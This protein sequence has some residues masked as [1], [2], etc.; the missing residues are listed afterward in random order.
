MVLRMVSG[1]Y[2]KGL[3]GWLG[4][5]GVEPPL[6]VPSEA[7]LA[8]IL[9]ASNVTTSSAKPIRDLYTILINFTTTVLILP[10]PGAWSSLV[11]DTSTAEPE[12]CMTRTTGGAGGWAE[13]EQ[14]LLA[15][16]F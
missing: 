14:R 8:C 10:P 15:R 7:A 1:L 13:D 4:G 3:P 12:T 16:V 2:Y 9:M 6:V 5:G 11:I